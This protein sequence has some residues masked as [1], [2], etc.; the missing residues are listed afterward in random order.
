VSKPS[1]TINAFF[2]EFL[3]QSSP[4]F[5]PYVPLQVTPSLVVNN[6]LHGKLKKAGLKIRVKHL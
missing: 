4:I 2:T 5:I 3:E 1:L 6:P